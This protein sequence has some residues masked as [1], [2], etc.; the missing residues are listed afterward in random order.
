M[1]LEPD[2]VKVLQLAGQWLRWRVARVCP[3]VLLMQRL[4][5]AK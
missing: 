1:R 3:R 2:T 5:R 4:G